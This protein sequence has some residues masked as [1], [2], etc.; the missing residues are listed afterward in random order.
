MFRNSLLPIV[1]IMPMLMSCTD[2]GPA[3]T[4]TLTVT[5]TAGLSD[6]G[7][8]VTIQSLDSK[9][10]P[11]GDSYTVYTGALGSYT[12]N[13]ITLNSSH[14]RLTATGYYY[15]IVTGLYT[16]WPLTLHAIS[17]ISSGDTVNINL[18]TH[19]MHQRIA[20][21]ITAGSTFSEA[22][23]QAKREL[24]AEFGFHRIKDDLELLLTSESD[25]VGMFAAISSLISM[26]RLDGDLYLFMNRLSSELA[27]YG[28]FSLL[29]HNTFE[30]EISLLQPQL[31][32]ISQNITDY[33]KDTDKHVS[34]PDLI[35]FFDWNG[36]RVAGNEILTPDQQIILSKNEV[37]IDNEGGEDTVTISSPIA[38][39]RGKEEIIPPYTPVEPDPWDSLYT[40]IHNDN[41]VS[42]ID[43]DGHRIA[44]KMFPLDSGPDK[45]F[46]I[47]LY[48]YLGNEVI[49]LVVTQ[50][51]NGLPHDWT[52][53][54]SAERALESIRD[55]ITALL[56][57]LQHIEDIYAD[58][59]VDGRFH[60]LITPRSP[61]ISQTFAAT[62]HAI[63]ALIL[64]K[65]ADAV[66]KSLYQRECTFWISLVYLII[67]EYWDNPLY[68][69]ALDE[70]ERQL[71]NSDILSLLLDDIT[72]ADTGIEKPP[73]LWFLVR[74]DA[75]RYITG[76][77]YLNQG[78]PLEAD[79]ELSLITQDIDATFPAILDSISGSTDSL[80]VISRDDIDLM[81]A[82]CHYLLGN[83]AR[84]AEFTAAVASRHNLPVSADIPDCLG[85]LRQALRL[86]PLPCH[87]RLGTASS[88]YN[89]I[90]EKATL[91]IP[92]THV[93]YLPGV[94]QNP[95][96]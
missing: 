77:L 56:I 15:N 9:M 83:T 65:D 35:Y 30:E 57:R 25:G 72:E 31:T 84:A 43:F 23:R 87:K 6:E 17:E 32:Q 74:N 29:S 2:D 96:W 69:T 20:G 71:R 37:I 44:I 60:E 93:L 61:T 51:G 64:L 54:G 50:K 34:I 90:P 18:L 24:L 40:T 89:V 86:Y 52:I 80:T 78:K 81:R 59:P 4:V 12:F 73:A 16:A 21:L 45:S 88:R 48:D 33:Y 66:R 47:P 55:N 53:G 46:T 7:T 67:T 79:R 13:D 11:T 91:P 42:R 1:T 41:P 14:V 75:M 76:R 5:G 49:R 63:N 8:A 94:S 19:V 85:R 95:G 38:V 22:R 28:E 70:P 26:N 36:D 82:E 3:K 68:R 27:D 10:K 92:A 58:N 62:F 39:F